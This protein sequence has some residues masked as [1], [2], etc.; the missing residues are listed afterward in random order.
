MDELSQGTEMSDEGKSFFSPGTLSASLTL[1]TSIASFIF[2]IP[3]VAEVIL[4]LR[5]QELTF[6]GLKNLLDVA[7]VILQT[8]IFTCHVC[9]FHLES[10]TFGVIL[11]TQCVLLFT[12]VQ[13]F[14]Q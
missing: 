11:A 7:V 6:F 2:M 3:F 4:A 5:S 8:C 1:L 14:G 12:K 10:T 9:S 13:N